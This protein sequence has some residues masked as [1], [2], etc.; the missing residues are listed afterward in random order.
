MR[1]SS[2]L[3]FVGALAAAAVLGGL[4]MQSLAEEAVAYE[5]VDE[6][7][8]P[9]PLTGKPGD[10]DK[11]RETFIN[12][13]LGNCLGCH[14]VT[15]LEAEPFHGEV[16]P[17]LDGVAD[18]YE[19]GELRLQVVNAKVVNPDTIMPGFYVTEGLHRVAEK[20]EGK[21]ILSA[22]EVE[23]IVAYLMTLKES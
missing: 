22:E 7:S 12:R 3:T 8:I 9:E 10:P 16:G 2:S 1:S 23:D 21:T 18:R 19:E 6:T 13:K 14:A 4:S 15:E 20:F 5:I 17:P 11:G